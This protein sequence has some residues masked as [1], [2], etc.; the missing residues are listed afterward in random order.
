MVLQPPEDLVF[1]EP[2]APHPL[3]LVVEPEP[4]PEWRRCRNRFYLISVVCDDRN[5]GTSCPPSRQMLRFRILVYDEPV[6]HA[7]SSALG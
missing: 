6:N 7:G 2:A 4:T 5:E 1:G 3:V